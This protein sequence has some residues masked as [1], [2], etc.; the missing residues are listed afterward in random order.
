MDIVLNGQ[1]ANLFI[2]RWRA[3]HFGSKK[4]LHS[5]E[6]L[7]YCVFIIVFMQIFYYCY[8]FSRFFR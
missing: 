6:W 1:K 4:T 2:R 8:F 7:A 5:L 3:R